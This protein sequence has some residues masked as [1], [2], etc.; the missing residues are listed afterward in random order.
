AWCDWYGVRVTDGCATVFKAVNDTYRS[1]K[2]GDY[3]P[4]TTPAADDWDGGRAECGGGLHFSPTPTA[5]REFN[6][7]ATRYVACPV[8]LSEMRPP[9]ATDDYPQKIKAARC[10]A[11]C[12]EVDEDGEPV[13]PGTD[14]PNAATGAQGAQE[15]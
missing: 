5:A 2:G 10:A 15:G 7:E 12:R 11:P 13:V 1:P 9:K 3:T 8:C 4:G 14:D 6:P